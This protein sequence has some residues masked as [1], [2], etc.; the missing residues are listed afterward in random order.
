MPLLF[1]VLAV[2]LGQDANWD[3]RN[4][5]WYNAYAAVNGRSDFDVAP[6]Q[7]PNFYNPTL[8]I[9]FYLAAT[10]LPAKVFAFLF[11]T[12]QGC[13]FI[14]LYLIAMRTLTLQSRQRQMA[15]SL[16]IAFIGMIGAG[17]LAQLGAMFYDNIVS[18]FILA[19]IA[20]LFHNKDLLLHGP[21]RRALMCSALAGLLVGFGVGLKLPTQI[22]AVGVCFG[23]LFIPGPFV[24]RFFL[25]FVCGLG[26]IAG[27]AVCGGWW[28]WEMWTHYGNP[29][30]PYFN[31]VIKSPWAIPFNYRDE[32]YLPKTVVDALTL[33][34][35]MFVD[36][37]VVGE[38]DFRDGR[39]LGV[40][41]ILIVTAIMLVLKRFEKT[42]V[43]A[44]PFADGFAARYLAAVTVLSYLA[45]LKL[46]GIYRYMLPL[47]M[48]APL[49]V[50][51]CLAFWPVR[52]ARQVS[53][54]IAVL[55]FMVL[56]MQPGSW[57]RK[58]W[59]AGWGGK[60]VDVKLPPIPDPANT[61]VIMTGLAPT[62]FLLP[63]FPP[64]IPFLRPHSFVANPSHPTKLTE[65]IQ[66]RID[67]HKGDFMLLRA[68]YEIWPAH[69]LL[70]LLGLTLVPD[71]CNPIW[72][73]LDGEMELCFLARTP[74]LDITPQIPELPSNP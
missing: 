49:T 29:L 19:A 5:H 4:Y 10:H 37:K 11:G 47:E 42:A 3:L 74:P 44:P 18:L 16:A 17:Q 43:G 34:F 23:L 71:S 62:S 56:T 63:A 39:V 61:M 32:R 52:H 35:R 26:I 31:D 27:F 67:D 2:I 72:D 22:F 40:Y 9:P 65:L 54:A 60:V 41:V 7:T 58:P 28:M 14:L 69:A 66:K 73:N 53:L 36:A 8:D 55:G 13:N 70:P 38:I 50:A 46:F 30:F 51:A 21:F 20:V 6:A 59:G 24:R 68:R 12:L 25:S 45:W 48:L 15:T 1:G 33:P 57:G 64:E